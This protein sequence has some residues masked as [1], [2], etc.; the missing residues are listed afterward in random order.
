MAPIH[1]WRLR[2]SSLPGLLARKR[3]LRAVFVGSGLF[4]LLERSWLARRDI[5]ITRHRVVAPVAPPIRIAHV[6]DLHVIRPGARERQLLDALAAE[7][8]DAIVLT[9]DFTD[10][11]GDPRACGEVLERLSAPL[12]VWAT[13]GNWDY[14]HPVE[15]WPEFLSDR[16]VRLLR[17]ASARLADAVWLA[18]LDSAVAGYPDP[19]V[20]LAGVPPGGFVIGLLHCPVLFDDVAELFPLALAGHTHGGQIRIPGLP[21]LHL[22]RGCRPYSAG[23]YDRGRSRMYVNR[24]IGAPGL[25]VRLACPPEIAIFTLGTNG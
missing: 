23:W 20:A 6:T 13:L 8:P 24:G 11:A 3:A 18:G 4:G 2:D 12:G 15:D 21:P 25:P 10:P 5:E 22:P 19:Q 17:N 16:G 9:G 14:W 1:R 7:R